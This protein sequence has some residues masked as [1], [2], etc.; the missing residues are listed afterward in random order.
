[1]D[2]GQKP[3]MKGE[4]DARPA[5]LCGSMSSVWD[6]GFAWLAGWLTGQVADFSMSSTAKQVFYL[7]AAICTVFVPYQGAR[8]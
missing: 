1:M 6:P 3:E 4:H 8:G 2:F 5:R 7:S